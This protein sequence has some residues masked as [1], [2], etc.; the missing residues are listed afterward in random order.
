MPEANALKTLYAGRHLSMVARGQWEFV[1]RNTNRPAVGIVAITDDQEVV[2]V[3]Q[4]RPP[5]GQTVTTS[6]PWRAAS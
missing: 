5:V 3:E 1:T 4:F 6:I 2:L